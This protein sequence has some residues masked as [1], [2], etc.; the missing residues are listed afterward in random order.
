MA[1]KALWNIVFR[2]AAV[3]P[4]GADAFSLITSLQ[5]PVFLKKIVAADAVELWTR[6]VVLPR[7]IGGRRADVVWWQVDVLQD[8]IRRE[9]RL[10]DIRQ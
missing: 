8:T 4:S 1:K 7:A 10:P 6:L 3:I 9:G 2:I 5:L